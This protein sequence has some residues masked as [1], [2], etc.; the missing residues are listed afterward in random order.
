MRKGGRGGERG[1]GRDGM[2]WLGW[3]QRHRGF[4]ERAEGE[5]RPPH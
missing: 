5:S 4:R 3:E 1:R 2:G